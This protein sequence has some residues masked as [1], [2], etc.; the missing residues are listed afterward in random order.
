MDPFAARV[1][2]VAADIPVPCTDFDPFGYLLF[3]S[4]YKACL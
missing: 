1:A 3:R 4:F 2:A